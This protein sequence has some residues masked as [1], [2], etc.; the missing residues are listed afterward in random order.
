MAAETHVFDLIISDI[1]LPDGSGYD[2]MRHMLARRP[3][4]GIAVSG[5]GMAADLLRAR[6]AGFA[7]HLTK[8]INLEQLELTIKHVTGSGSGTT[9]GSCLFETPTND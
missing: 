7:A 4:N 8:P 9:K 2:V 6:D 5:Y 3:T 1:G